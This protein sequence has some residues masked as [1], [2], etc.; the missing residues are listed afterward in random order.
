MK[1][2][3]SIDFAILTSII[4]IFLFI[5]GYFY[6]DSYTDFFGY[7]QTSLGFSFQDYL[8][9]GW[10][11]NLLTLFF[12]FVVFILISLVN[13]LQEKDLYESTSKIILG[14]FIF[15]FLVFWKILSKFWIYIV[16]IFLIS[17]SNYLILLIFLPL[18]K[19][20]IYLLKKLALILETIIDKLRPF[21]SPIL[22]QVK[23]TVD[24]KGED[25]KQEVD[26]AMSIFSSHYIYFVLFY[27]IF[28][29]VLIYVIYVGR[30]GTK[31]A[32][33][34]FSAQNF[35]NIIVKNELFNEWVKKRSFTINYPVSAKLLL[36]GSNKC[37]VGIPYSNIKNK[38]FETIPSQHNY[39]IMTVSP[40]QY[41]IIK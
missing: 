5:G 27:L 10:I 21:F 11:N 18:K 7:N 24:W 2:K 25:E 32:Q 4:S 14:F 34:D 9:Y 6:L 16:L 12:I 35:Q 19:I 28:I 1:H 33:K 22:Q 23:E 30:V 37:L 39:L 15:T 41:I 20:S 40:D 3:L 13:T 26:N 31:E 38:K 17:I 8:I 36:C 29:A